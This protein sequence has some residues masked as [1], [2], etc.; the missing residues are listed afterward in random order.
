[1]IE[2]I[3]ADITTL[4]VDAIVNAA[5][6]SLLGG[7]G[8]DGAIHRAAGPELLEACRKIGGCPTG[9]ARITPGFRLPARFVI[10]TV[11]P[12]WRGGQHQ[13]P[14]LLR[15]CYMNSFRLAQDHDVRT[16]AFPAVSTG[17]YGY[18]KQAAATLALQCMAAYEPAFERIIVCCFSPAEAQI[19]TQLHGSAPA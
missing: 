12:I 5:N 9:E 16:I 14:E 6:T 2:I 18:P 15:A 8:V 7:G 10:H 13:E 17:A 4:H 3:Q 11:G 19:Y 1:M